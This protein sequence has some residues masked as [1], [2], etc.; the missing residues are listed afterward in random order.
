MDDT[1]AVAGDSVSG[2]RARVRSAA[3]PEGRAELRTRA[4]RARRTPRGGRG[5][6]SDGLGDDEREVMVALELVGGAVPEVECNRRR[7]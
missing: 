4:R 2:E 7:L 1:V 6:R 3:S 5:Y